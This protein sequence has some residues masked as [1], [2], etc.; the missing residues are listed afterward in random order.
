MA[1]ACW[2]LLY[3]Q[4]SI[5]DVS[6]MKQSPKRR[7]ILEP[8]EIV[9]VPVYSSKVSS[10]LNL[11]PTAVL[12]S[13]RD[14][15]DKDADDS[16]WDGFP[17]QLKP[18]YTMTTSDSEDESDL[19]QSRQDGE[20]QTEDA[21]CPSPPPPES[22]V[23]KRSRRVAQKIDE[24]NKRLRAVSS[25]LSPEPEYS[26]SRRHWTP[27]SSTPVVQL[28]DD[29]DDDIIVTPGSPTSPYCSNT[30][31]EIPLKIWCRTEIHKIPV[32]SSTPLSD[33]VTQLSVI[34]NVPPPRLLLLKEEA[35][36]PT[37]S[38]I[39]ELG[40]GIADIIECVVIPAEEKSNSSN[41][42]SVT[43]QSKDRA[44]S[45]K[46][47]VGRDAPLSTVFSRYMSNMPAATQRK[48]CFLFDGAKVTGSQ[49]PA[50]LDME[51]GDIVEVW[52]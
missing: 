40:L 20:K 1:K 32:L 52:T 49:T 22:P 26:R 16:M 10:S 51:D 29:D 17:S 8:S 42:I 47:S 24:V 19:D 14:D 43:L 21:H 50:Q 35:E 5:S 41:I 38:T 13:K 2:F 37:D 28:E 25:V 46:F 6:A 48:V 7:R 33:V 23:Q 44:A 27:L 9:P 4:V 34:L 45:Q 30:V 11:K 12:F 31:R 3:S 36:L 15:A 18:A 39:R